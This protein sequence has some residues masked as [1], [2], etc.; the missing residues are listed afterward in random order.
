MFVELR[1]RFKK[2]EACEAAS[3]TLLL[4]MDGQKTGFERTEV[5]EWCCCSWGGPESEKTDDYRKAVRS[6]GLLVCWNFWA[7]A[8]SFEI[9]QCLTEGE[10]P[11]AMRESSHSAETKDIVRLPNFGQAEFD[12]SGL[13]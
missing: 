12:V 13:G 11:S 2:S 5:A 3:A 8:L 4:R 7:C 10:S 9:E 1:Q 6:S